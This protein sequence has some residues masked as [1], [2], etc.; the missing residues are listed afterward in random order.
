MQR[1]FPFGEWLPRY[2]WGSFLKA[3]LIAAISVAALLIP[4]S[5]G[6]SSVAGV[7]VQVGLYAAPL[8]LLAYAL[9]GGSK[10]L[11]V[12]AAGAVA[13]MSA[14][15]VGEL[16]GGDQG[17]AVVLTAA[18]AIATGA[19]FLG[20][21]LAKLGWVT[22]FISK[23][24]MAGFILGMGIQIIIGQLGKLVG[25]EQ[26][27]SNS[28][29]KLW[30]VLSKVGE[31][32][33]MTVAV[34]GASLILIF[35]MERFVPKLPAA[36]TAVVLA[37]V[38]VAVA[39][40]DIHL[41][42][43]IPRGLPS[44]ALPTGIDLTTWGELFV[45]S[46]ALVLIAVSES[47]GASAA[48]AEQT[49]DQL[50]SDQE[51]RALGI[52]NLGSG[53]LGG[54]SVAGSLSKT[55]AAASAGAKTQMANIILAGLVLLT[56]AFLAPAFQWL[57]ETVL[58]AVVINALWGAANP[59]KVTWM[60]GIDKVE[61]AIAAI[62]LVLVLSL[63]LL[64][65]MIAGV[66]ISIGFMVYRISFPAREVL[67][68]VPDSGD[69]VTTDWI[70]G[71]RRGTAHPDAEPVPGVIVYRF[72]APLFFANAEAFVESGQALLVAAGEA[73]NLPHTMVIDFEEVFLV[74][75]NG[76]TAITNLFEY[77]QRYEIDIV[78][79]R[80]H[81]NTHKIME[82]LGVV[83]MIGEDR[84]YPTVRSAVAAVTAGHASPSTE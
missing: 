25:V 4:E 70:Y 42:A 30:S 84:I 43:E 15:V 51:F 65:A 60:W 59:S 83:D 11:V 69:F 12:S 76:A 56:L 78:F 82:L 29:E 44:F 62:T 2:Q 22:N 46:I 38:F 57:P 5:M 13:A 77:A 61:F 45:G 26:E 74:D 36:L 80:V 63:D 41:I 1:W 34:G 7:P 21:G 50:D 19:V 48:V 79:A 64:P 58:A 71:H 20:A 27:G 49:H 53:V 6:Y 72:A 35:G 47:T 39:G 55:A 16:A 24:V 37:S 17:T 32:D 3:D 68:R 10:L 14:S 54:M 33:W 9:F 8:A 31:W 40:P 23:A 18:L 73:G 28:F 75:G 81:E 67:G 66:V 52:S